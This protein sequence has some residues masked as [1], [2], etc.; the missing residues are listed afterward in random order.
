MGGGRSVTQGHEETF[1]GG[2]ICSLSLLWG[3]FHRLYIYQGLSS[4]VFKYVQFI[5]CQFYLH[6][7]I[8]KHI[9]NLT[10]SPQHCC[11]SFI[12]TSI[13]SHMVNWNSPTTCPFGTALASW[14][15]LLNTESRAMLL[16]GSEV[17]SLLYLKPYNGF[18][19][20]PITLR[21]L[22]TVWHTVYLTSFLSVLPHGDTS[23][24]T[25]GPFLSTAVSLV[26]RTVCI[27]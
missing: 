12:Q 17:I 2:W 14:H 11:C 8:K 7:A 13:I 18:P 5:V 21:A 16:K 25:A 27:T 4:Y 6:Q 19:W 15:T 23:S 9:Q 20:L 10:A 3:W 22:I 26:S 1:L 24:M